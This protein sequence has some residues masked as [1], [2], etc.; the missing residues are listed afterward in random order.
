[1]SVFP[2]SFC[3]RLDGTG[4]EVTSRLAETE[5]ILFF[6]GLVAQ[7]ILGNFGKFWEKFGKG[8]DYSVPPRKSLE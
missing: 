3:S 1:M 5:T 6:P 8:Q 7:K 4:L 2:V